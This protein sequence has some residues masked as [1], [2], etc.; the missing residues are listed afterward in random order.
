MALRQQL[1]NVKTLLQKCDGG[2]VALH[3][4]LFYAAQGL[5]YRKLQVILTTSIDKLGKAGE[6][7]KVAPGYFRNHLMPKLLAVP[8]IDKYR[9][10][11]EDQRKLYQREE[12]E[13]VKIVPATKEDKMKEYQMAANRL[14]RTKLVLRKLAKKPLTKDDSGRTFIQEPIGK[15]EIVA[16]VAK[17]LSVHIEPEHLVLDTPLHVMG[18]FEIPLRMPRSIPLPEG[19]V[20]WILQ[21]KIRGR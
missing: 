21:V 15:D 13:E 11:M 3:H 19:K 8:N 4:P 14:D 17:Q 1:K 9:H 2:E 18:E 10:L 16:E 5:R 20:Q 12:V 7:V 6:T